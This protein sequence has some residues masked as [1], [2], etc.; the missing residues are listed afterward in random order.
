SGFVG[1]ATASTLEERGHEVIRAVGSRSAGQD[2][3]FPIDIADTST[4]DA[5]E[6][7][8]SIDACVHCA[9]LAHRRGTVSPGEYSRVNAEGAGNAARLARRL[10]AER[11]IH[12]S[13]VSVYGKPGSPRP[14]TESETPRPQDEYSKSKLEGE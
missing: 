11:F 2:G 13:S 7:I 3:T 6:S 8:E 14:I 10:G 5:L 12:L 1:A 9:G 4:F